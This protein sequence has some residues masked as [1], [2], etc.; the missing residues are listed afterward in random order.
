MGANNNQD[1]EEDKE[2]KQIWSLF[3]DSPED[4][5]ERRKNIT[6]VIQDNTTSV[7][8]TQISIFTALDE[9][10]ACFSLGGQVKNYYRYGNYDVCKRQREKFWFAIKNGGFSES[11]D[12]VDFSKLSSKDL[13]KYTKIQDFYKNRVLEDK[14]LGSSEDIWDERKE[15]LGD[16]FKK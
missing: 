16:P 1:D 4:I 5:Q 10:I 14:A 9:L 7:Y 6:K 15:L 12:N 2:L 11:N 3:Q 8:P 13:S